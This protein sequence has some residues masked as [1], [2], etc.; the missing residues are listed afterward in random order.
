MEEWMPMT[1]KN[2]II[3]ED[4]PQLGLLTR[5]IISSIGIQTR[6]VD[7]GALAIQAIAET[8]PDLVILDMH[9]PNVSGAEILSR[10]RADP[11]LKDTK[12]LISTAD[13]AMIE[14]NEGLA[15]GCIVKPFDMKQLIDAVRSQI[16][17]SVS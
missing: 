14:A 7:D 15:N 6:L 16:A 1:A 12:V 13:T 8:Q 10:L 3:V 5:E 4:D 11:A 9:L 2:V 17:S